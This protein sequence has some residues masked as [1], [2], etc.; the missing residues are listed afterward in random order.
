M[1]QPPADMPDLERLAFYRA[2][3]AAEEERAAVEELMR[4]KGAGENL[5]DAEEIEL[6]YAGVDVVEVY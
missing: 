3:R 6:T 2:A 1:Q 5:T 4:R